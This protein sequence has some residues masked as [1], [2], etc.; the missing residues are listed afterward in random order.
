VLLHLGPQPLRQPGEPLGV[1]ASIQAPGGTL[2]LLLGQELQVVTSGGDKGVNQGI[3]LLRYAIHSITR[4]AQRSE[5]PHRA[6][7]GIQ[8]DGVTDPRVLGRVVRE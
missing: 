7:R 8:A 6:R 2:E 4:L 5:Q 3:A 1:E